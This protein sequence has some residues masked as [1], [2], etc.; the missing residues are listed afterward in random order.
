MNHHPEWFNV[1]NKASFFYNTIFSINALV[2]YIAEMGSIPHQIYQ[3][4]MYQFRY[5]TMSRYSEYLLK[6]FTFQV[7]LSWEKYF[8][9]KKLNGKLICGFNCFVGNFNSKLINS[10]FFLNNPFQFWNLPHVWYV[11]FLCYLI[12]LKDHATVYKHAMLILIDLPVS[13]PDYTQHTWCWRCLWKRY[14][15]GEIYRESGLD[16]HAY[17]DMI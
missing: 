8:W 4:Q 9:I 16:I 12:N 17:N 1:Y 14:N 10:I 5:F 11:V 6:W 3:F 13:G 15:T 2:W 7:G